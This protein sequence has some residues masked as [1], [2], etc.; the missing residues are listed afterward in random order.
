MEQSVGISSKTEKDIYLRTHGKALNTE[1]ITSAFVMIP[2]AITD[3]GCTARCRMMSTILNTSH[4]ILGKSRSLGRF[5]VILP[6][7]GECAA[8]MNSSDM[9]QNRCCRQLDTQWSPLTIL[10][11][12]PIVCEWNESTYTSQ[13]IDSNRI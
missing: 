12:V 2:V 8:G 11:L 10:L 5:E 4:L 7:S 9:L 6:S 3:R 13:A 1:V